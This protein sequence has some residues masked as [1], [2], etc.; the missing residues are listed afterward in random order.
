MTSNEQAQWVLACKSW[1]FVAI[2]DFQRSFY[3]YFN[4]RTIWKSMMVLCNHVI[5]W[6]TLHLFYNK[7][8][9]KADI[10]FNIY[11]TYSLP[12]RPKI[13]FLL[14][15]NTFNCLRLLRAIIQWIFY[16]EPDFLVIIYAW[17]HVYSDV[18]VLSNTGHFYSNTVKS[19]YFAWFLFLCI[20]H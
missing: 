20:S 16:C 12:N 3:I 19:F 1:I 2:G 9:S 6:E 10:L 17:C 14:T 7:R 5:G 18:C 13:T 8:C 11:P 15:F 4:M